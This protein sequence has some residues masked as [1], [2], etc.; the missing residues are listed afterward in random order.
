M[1]VVAILAAYAYLSW[2]LS[3]SDPFIEARSALLVLVAMALFTAKRIRA[4]AGFR[5]GRRAILRALF[6]QPAW[7]NMWYPR[8]WRRRGD[9]FDRLPAPY[10]LARTI[11]AGF[12]PVY[13]FWTMPVI[14]VLQ[15]VMTRHFKLIPFGY[16]AA[17]A[18]VVLLLLAALVVQAVRA[19]RWARRHGAGRVE[20]TRLLWASTAKRALWTRPEMARLLQMNVPAMPATPQACLRAVVAMAEGVT[21]PARPA[22]DEAGAAARRLLTVIEPIDGELTRLATDSDPAEEGRLHARLAAFGPESA[23]EGDDRRRMR[24]LLAQQLEVVVA[25]RDRIVVLQEQRERMNGALTTL[26][27]LVAELVDG[28]PA[29]AGG[30]ALEGRLHDASAEAFCLADSRSTVFVGSSPTEDLPT[31]PR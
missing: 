7:W 24:L 18:S 15:G 12:V 8:G 11:M 20:G 19:Q 25:M 16:V 1:T 28:L 3:D 26:Y 4:R 13:L 21:G 23:A 9:V 17:P 30:R 22:V 31:L 2:L 6:L 29:G 5:L 14:V 10:R 27:R